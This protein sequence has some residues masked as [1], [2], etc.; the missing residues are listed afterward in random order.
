MRMPTTGRFSNLQKCIHIESVERLSMHSFFRIPLRKNSGSRVWMPRCHVFILIGCTHCDGYVGSVLRLLVASVNFQRDIGK[1]GE[2]MNPRASQ[3]SHS[4]HGACP[5]KTSH[6]KNQV[7]F[8]PCGV[9][10]YNASPGDVRSCSG[11]GVAEFVA[12]PGEGHQGVAGAVGL[13][14]VV[15]RIVPPRAVLFLAFQQDRRE[16]LCVFGALSLWQ[17]AH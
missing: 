5:R 3:W 1:F 10:W 16:A 17:Q 6:P 2:Q 11:P 15:E 12:A 14:V 8:I 4:H 13:V 9:S 7:W